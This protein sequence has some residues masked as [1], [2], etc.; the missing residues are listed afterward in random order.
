MRTL[1]EGVYRFAP[2]GDFR[3]LESY[4]RAVRSAQRLV[5]IENQFLWAPEVVM[6]LA[7]KLQAPEPSRPPENHQQELV[8]D[9]HQ[10]LSRTN[11]PGR[12]DSEDPEIAH[13]ANLE[14]TLGEG[15]NSASTSP[16]GC[17]AGSCLRVSP[18]TALQRAAKWLPTS[19]ATVPESERR[20]SASPDVWGRMDTQVVTIAVTIGEI[21]AAHERDIIVDDYGH[22]GGG[23]GMLA[24][25]RAPPWEASRLSGRPGL[26]GR[27]DDPD[28]S[29]V[30][31]PQPTGS[32]A[33]PQCATP[34]TTAG[35][36][37]SV[38][39]TV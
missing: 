7:R 24:P 11:G 30:P 39:I 35:A 3:I 2:K 13:G 4:L 27:R 6:V 21:E 20:G 22:G 36:R 8:L 16:A 37:P 31:A 26:G 17:G 28:E 19:P 1:P 23:D 9:V 29:P 14:I 38:A 34:L 33:L 10:P 32:L 5:Y 18:V 25:V 15:K 12:Y